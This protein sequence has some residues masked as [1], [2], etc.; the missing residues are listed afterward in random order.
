MESFGASGNVAATT[1]EVVAEI[2]EQIAVD[3]EEFP[4]SPLD[5]LLDQ[6]ETRLLAGRGASRVITWLL[7]I[8]IPR[9]VCEHL[10]CEV[11][12]SWQLQH[13]SYEQ[14]QERRNLAR[15]RLNKIYELAMSKGDLKNAT[16]AVKHL[17]DLDGLEAPKTLNIN[18]NVATQQIT[19]A[20]RET[21]AQLMERMRRL[22]E[23]KRAKSLNARGVAAQ[24]APSALAI[25]DVQ[26][27]GQLPPDNE[28][29]K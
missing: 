27:H 19:N 11:R 16:A 26:E 25:I 18:A 28:G 14:Y 12:R 10:I 4:P 2:D 5:R 20:S 8:G 1:E 3:A 6:I 7:G 22:S 15:A 21:V 17:V 9:E 23:A 24:A 13:D 29:E